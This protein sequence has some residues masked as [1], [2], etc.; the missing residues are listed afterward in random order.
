MDL[1]GES[2]QERWARVEERVQSHCE[3]VE[4]P[5]PRETLEAVRPWFASVGAWFDQAGVATHRPILFP[6]DVDRVLRV[7]READ[8]LRAFYGEGRKWNDLPE[9]SEG[10]DFFTS[11][12]RWANTAFLQVVQDG[13]RR[14]PEFDSRFRDSTI[15]ALAE[16][17]DLSG[18]G[19]NWGRQRRLRGA[20]KERARH[21]KGVDADGLWIQ[22]LATAVHM[23]IGYLYDTV[24]VRPNPLD[25]EGYLSRLSVGR[26]VLLDRLESL[27]DPLDWSDYITVKGRYPTFDA[28]MGSSL[29]ASKASRI[30]MR[31][32][33]PGVD[34][35]ELR[36]AVERVISEDLLGP[37][38]RKI[39]R[40]DEPG[41]PESLNVSVKQRRDVEDD[42]RS[43]LD[44][45]ESVDPNFG[46]FEAQ[47][48]LRRLIDKADLTDS[49]HE[50]L[51]YREL[52]GFSVQETAEAMNSTEGSVR[53]L[54]SQAKSALHQAGDARDLP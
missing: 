36:Y 49:Q 35:S 6:P 37:D 38:A 5:Y 51:L 42:G 4:V 20:V 15:L 7:I 54:V 48:T 16:Y 39:L 13:Q 44:R 40:S 31:N 28:K 32:L 1:P 8:Q 43:L 46:R 29:K 14:E 25:R 3:E 53:A 47:L 34:P 21:W 30:L 24:T 41:P 23:A 12:I 19:V 27:P 45:L 18:P 33:M 10:Y 26:E 50:A 52:R 11:T 9:F 2:F 22:V 17:V